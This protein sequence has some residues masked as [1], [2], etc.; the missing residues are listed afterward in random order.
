MR[1]LPRTRPANNGATRDHVEVSEDARERSRR[2]IRA[3]DADR[4]RAVEFVRS[5]AGEGRL[6]VD[7]LEDRVG[8][9]LTAKTLGDLDDLVYDLPPLPTSRPAATSPARPRWRSPLPGSWTWVRYAALA[10][11]LAAIVGPGPG[12]GVLFIPW[13]WIGVFF[14]VRRGRRGRSAGTPPQYYGA[15]GA[16]GPPACCGAP[17]MARPPATLEWRPPEVDEPR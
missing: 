14:L 3:S 5:H 15:P 8:R 13:L 17:E 4:E 1:A 10:L 16:F 9:A 7:E 2:G 12:R 6:T 11:F